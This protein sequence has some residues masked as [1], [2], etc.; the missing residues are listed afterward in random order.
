LQGI[1]YLYKTYDKIPFKIAAKAS[2]KNNRKSAESIDKESK[3]F[4]NIW[5]IL[6][7]N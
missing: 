4:K 5:E 3:I 1:V 2:L 6:Q 7:A